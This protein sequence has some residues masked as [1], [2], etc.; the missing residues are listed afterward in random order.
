MCQPFGHYPYR[1]LVAA[2]NFFLSHQTDYN[3]AIFCAT[4]FS[5]CLK[6]FFA[7]YFH[8]L[9]PSLLKNLW[10]KTLPRVNK[11]AR[12][13][14]PLL[15]SLLLPENAFEF[16]WNRFSNVLKLKVC[17]CC[18]CA[19]LHN[20]TSIS[21]TRCNNKRKPQKRPGMPHLKTCYLFHFA[22]FWL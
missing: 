21:V 19:S 12:Q 14:W 1:G 6:N 18:C 11:L 3:D 17:Y 20:I 9:L 7:F 2:P 10:N 13:R 22:T 16:L 5:F 15:I 8:K 4:F